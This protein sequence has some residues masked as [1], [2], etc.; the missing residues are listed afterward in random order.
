MND[1]TSGSDSREARTLDDPVMGFE[2]DREIALLREEPGY[3][4]FGRSS[5]TLGKSRNFRL[6]VTAARAGTDLGND[7]A[8]AAMAIQVLDG[9][10]TATRAGAGMRFGRGSVIWFAEGEDWAVRV[11]DDAA[12]VLSIGWPGGAAEDN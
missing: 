3:A 9:A 12:L 7:D 10:V 5:K 11:E 4:Q 1:I 2:L 6:V 8:E